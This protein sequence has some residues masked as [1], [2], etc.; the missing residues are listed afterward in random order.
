MWYA[1][2]KEGCSMSTAHHLNHV[3]LLILM[4]GVHAF[5]NI[6]NSKFYNLKSINCSLSSKIGL[7]DFLLANLLSLA[8]FAK[9]SIGLYRSGRTPVYCRIALHF[10]HRPQPEKKLS[11]LSS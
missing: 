5:T 2:S 4:H 7:I 6:C 9:R 8:M 10:T 11:D 3:R 1:D